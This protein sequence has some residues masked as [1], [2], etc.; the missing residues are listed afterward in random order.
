MTAD[1]R[2][3][4]PSDAAAS[5]RAVHENRAVEI[6]LIEAN[7]GDVRLLRE[8]FAEAGIGNDV[9]VAYTADE[10]LDFVL[11]RGEYVDAP[12]PDVVLADL[13][14]F[15]TRSE[16]VVDAFADHLELREIPT[17]VL[18]SSATEADLVR[19]AGIDADA[20]VQKPIDPGEF[21][22]LVLEFDG[23]GIT[24]VR[25]SADGDGGSS[26]DRE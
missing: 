11:R 24:V 20:Y 8:L 6:L 26:R 13:H 21:V 16:G 4:P 10:A 2:S 1:R 17:I 22:D 12:R 15:E 7:R 14:P 5:G 25:E 23:F 3:D 19:S 9:H 18:A